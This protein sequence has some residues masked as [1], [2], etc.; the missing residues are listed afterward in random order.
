M[1]LS[2]VN[3]TYF[4]C[5]RWWVHEGVAIIG[6]ELLLTGHGVLWHLIRYL[7]ISIFSLL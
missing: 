6:A 4:V 3:F 2:S 5:W 1:T 7:S